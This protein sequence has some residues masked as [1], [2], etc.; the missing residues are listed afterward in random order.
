[1][2]VVSYGLVALRSAPSFQSEQISQLF[3]SE[4]VHLLEVQGDWAHVRTKMDN[5]EG[6]LPKAL[7]EETAFLPC[8]PKMVIHKE[9]FVQ[10]MPVGRTFRLPLYSVILVYR[11]DKEKNLHLL[12]EGS[13]YFISAHFVSTCYSDLSL[14][15]L[16]ELAPAFIGVPYLWGGRSLWGIDCSGLTQLF[17]LLHKRF[18]PRDAYLQALKGN[19]ITYSEAQPGDLAFFGEKGR[20]SHVG[21]IIQRKKNLLQILHAHHSVSLHIL[22][23]NGIWDPFRQT[24]THSLVGI[25]RM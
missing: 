20:V 3:F 5:Y 16:S 8:I 10:E 15:S 23:P 2:Y 17:F 7:I 6:W 14:F 25:K 9:A 4:P 22:T 1:M 12:T 21:I 19:W 13:D 11:E 18:L 24:L